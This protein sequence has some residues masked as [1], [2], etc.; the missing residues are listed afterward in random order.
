M[1][2]NELLQAFNSGEYVTGMQIASSD[3]NIEAFG[4]VIWDQVV[5]EKVT[6]QFNLFDG[7]ISW[8]RVQPLPRELTPEE[9]HL[10]R[11]TELKS[12]VTRI[13]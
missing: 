1:K 13:I 4:K 6:G 10:S 11:P 5:Q 7:D 2:E 8:R 9:K 12:G 3:E